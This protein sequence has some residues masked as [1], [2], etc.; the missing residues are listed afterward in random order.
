MPFLNGD[1]ETIIYQYPQT[2]LFIANDFDSVNSNLQFLHQNH[3]T[4]NLIL[5]ALL[6]PWPFPTSIRLFVTVHVYLERQ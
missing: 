1:L 2:K 3:P 5:T 4:G 6:T